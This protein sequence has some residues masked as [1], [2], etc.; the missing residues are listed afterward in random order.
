LRVGNLSVVMTFLDTRACFATRCF[1]RP[2]GVCERALWFRSTSTVE[3]SH[4]HLPPLGDRVIIRVVYM[5]MRE[6]G[7]DS[8]DPLRLSP[9]LISKNTH[10]V[11][12]LLSCI[13][14]TGNHS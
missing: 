8:W 12:T 1:Y 3:V 10:P 2:C 5:P 11:L 13:A 4:S 9:A 6:F 7:T 14:M